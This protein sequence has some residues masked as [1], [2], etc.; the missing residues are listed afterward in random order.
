[1]DVTGD[2]KKELVLCGE[3]MA[4]RV[5]AFHEL[6]CVELKE[7]GLKNM[8]GLWQTVAAAD[9][10]GDGKQDLVLGNIGE[11]FYL[12]P[13]EEHPVKLWVGDLDGN[14][15][16]DQ[17]LTKTINGKDMPVFLKRD[18][19]EQFPMLKKENLRHSDYAVKT[20]Q[21][22]FPEAVLKQASIKEFN[23]CSS[24][25]ALNQGRGK[26][27]VT[28]LP[29]Q[30]QLSSV[31]AIAF[32]DLDGNGKPD[33]LLGGN[34]SIFPPQFGRLDASYGQ[35][36]LN[37]REGNF[38]CMP[39]ASS[40]LQWKGDV[41]DVRFVQTVAGPRMLVLRNNDTPLFY[42]LHEKRPRI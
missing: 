25:I 22:L 4:P 1:V 17:F 39:Q 27:S 19:T 37:R 34:S 8:S 33:L 18:V 2:G 9:I 11:N 10:N 28:S 41:K 5:F 32:R 20:I 31:H 24:V 6:N 35:V 3:Y 21:Q 7:T 42:K 26:F 30:A 15:T 12:R 36:W 38:A 14:G 40:G 23:F 13:D 16:Q 29:Y